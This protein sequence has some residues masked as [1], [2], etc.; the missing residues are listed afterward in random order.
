[1]KIIN[2]YR[3]I[4]PGPLQRARLYLSGHP[5]A[6]MHRKKIKSI[7]YVEPDY[8]S[9]IDQELTDDYISVDCAGWYFAAG[10]Q[11]TAIECHPVSSSQWPVLFEY[12]YMT[13]RPTYLPCDAVLCYHSTEFRY[14]TLAQF[15]GFFNTWGP[16]H[17][18]YIVGLDPTK[19]KFNYLK[20]RLLDQL[21]QLISWPHAIRTLYSADFELLFVLESV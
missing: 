21:S 9:A 16:Q 14:A 2:N 19:I 4:Q 1:M 20:Y 15:A 10:R 6:A 3:D 11:C 7:P 12:D 13:W 8:I 18:K 17:K 5:L